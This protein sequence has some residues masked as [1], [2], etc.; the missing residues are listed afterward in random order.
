MRISTFFGEEVVAHIAFGEPICETRRK[1]V[2]EAC[3]KEGVNVKL[4]G[5]YICMEGP[6][7]STKAE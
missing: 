4:G 5:T 6:Q 3:K 2:H 1:V 7:F